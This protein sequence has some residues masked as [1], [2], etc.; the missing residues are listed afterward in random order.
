[1]NEP[2]P[3]DLPLDIVVIGI[4]DSQCCDFR[5]RP[6]LAGPQAVEWIDKVVS[7]YL[8]DR[9]VHV[10]CCE[11]TPSYWLEP[12]Y[13]SVWTKAG[14]PDDLVEKFDDAYGQVGDGIYVH[15]ASL[16]RL[17]EKGGPLVHAKGPV[18]PDEDETYEECLAAWREHFMCNHVV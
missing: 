12:L 15:C 7:V 2:R 6:E 11:A 16:D 14:C 10:H 5:D 3:Q 8:V 9:S 1:M 13:V 18:L 17:V 4:D